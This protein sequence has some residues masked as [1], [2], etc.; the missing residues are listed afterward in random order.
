MKKSLI[1]FAMAF[2]V[3]LGNVA[4]SSDDSS[5]NNDN[6]GN[7]TKPKYA[8]QATAFTI[9]EGAVRQT[10]TVDGEEKPVDLRSVYF[11]DA[12]KAIFEVNIDKKVKYVTYDVTIE[13]NTYTIK[14]GS[15]VQGTISRTE[16]RAGGATLVFHFEINVPGYGVFRFDT[17]T[18]VSVVE[19]A[20]SIAGG[21]ICS[22]WYVERTKL[23]LDFDTKTDASTEVNSGKLHEFLTLAKNNGVKLSEQDEEEL[24]KEIVSFTLNNFSLF[25]IEYK[26]GNS[27]AAT[28][29][30]E[31]TSHD[32]LKIYLK[33]LDE[34]GNKFLNN[35]SVIEVKYPG[36]NK[37]VL[38]LTTRL[39]ED[40]CTAV[41]TVNLRE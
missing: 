17:D 15:L 1:Y 35:S 37:I 31:G 22:T 27:D 23:T 38:K 39:E 29:S 16:S 7:Y 36:D 8:D 41:L 25:S 9:N 6:K 14:K 28:W 2:F 24:N 33:D 5:D 32:K 4:C 34:M 19:L 21:D 30:W 13:G 11:T 10:I 18:P 12:G 3:A 26:D 20:V 40:A